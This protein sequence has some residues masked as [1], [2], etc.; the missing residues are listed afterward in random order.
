MLALTGG[1]TRPDAEDG[2]GNG[3]SGQCCAMFYGDSAGWAQAS[4]RSDKVYLEICLYF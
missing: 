1:M 3:A 4:L 2:D